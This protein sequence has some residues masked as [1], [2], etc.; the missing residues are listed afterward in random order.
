MKSTK[1]RKGFF[2]FLILL[3]PSLLYVVLSTGKH[4]IITLPFYTP[5]GKVELRADA[6][7]RV[8]A[9][10]LQSFGGSADSLVNKLVI[11]NLV[12]SDCPPSCDR[13]MGQFLSFT[14]K[15]ESYPD[16]WNQTVCLDVV[17]TTTQLESS[18]S[19]YLSKRKKWIVSYSD[20]QVQIDD[21]VLNGLLYADSVKNS[22][23]INSL[24]GKVVILDK[25]RKI[26]A[27]YDAT[28][29][30]DYSEIVDAV[31]VLKAEEFVPRK[32]KDERR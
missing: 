9:A 16:V 11:I 21:F 26:R 30:T 3:F 2:L 4:N 12:T 22:A 15:F 25:Q 10:P 29:Y 13:A 6:N 7:Y 24:S 20:S 27:Y 14:E 19:N 8:E 17:D 18:F 28:N 23:N 1:L 32:T 31:K 5:D